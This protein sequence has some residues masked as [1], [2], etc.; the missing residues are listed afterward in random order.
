MAQYTIFCSCGFYNLSF[1]PVGCECIRVS[2]ILQVWGNQRMAWLGRCFGA[3]KPFC[4]SGELINQYS[5]LF[6]SDTGI[7]I[8]VRQ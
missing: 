8:P 6:V 5:D 1:N 3:C 4:S 7:S 2:A